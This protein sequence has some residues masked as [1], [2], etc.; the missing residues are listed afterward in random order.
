M[1]IVSLN[2]GPSNTI[3]ERP[4]YRNADT[5]VRWSPWET[6]NFATACRSCPAG[7]LCRSAGLFTAN[8]YICLECQMLAEIRGFM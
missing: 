4:L 1:S 5:R 2:E 6:Q 8:P 7:Q 3:V